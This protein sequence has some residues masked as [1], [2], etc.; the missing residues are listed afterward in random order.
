[1]HPASRSLI[2]RWI[3]AAKLD[4]WP[5]LLVPMLFG[6]ALGVA[7]AGRVSALAL[8]LG[9]A[10][11]ICELLFIVFLND[12]GDRRVDR[13]K[14]QMFPDDCSPKTIPDEILP[15]SSLLTAGVIAGLAAVGVAVAA[16]LLLARPSLGWAALGLQSMFLAYSFAPLRLNY[17]GGGEWLEGLGVGLALPCFH[18]FMQSGA[19]VWVRELWLVPGFFLLATASA[20]AS[21]LA[22]EQSDR[23]GGKRTY[24]SEYG[25]RA[26]R[27]LIERLVLAACLVWAVSM[28]ISGVIPGPI[29][30]LAVIVILVNWRRLRAVSP[31]AK[32]NEFAAQRRYK[33][34]LHQAQWRSAVL[35]SIALIGLTVLGWRG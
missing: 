2:G 4:S 25:N 10:F 21:G 16:E 15:A 31:D 34:F 26:A 32:T 9:L 5:K 3:Y 14:R 1:M 11:A 29:G 33:H 7:A 13:I 17:R 23:R 28:R 22:D 19:S 8:G 27:A 20:I 24:A 6:Q 35:L 18:M 30:A 12:W